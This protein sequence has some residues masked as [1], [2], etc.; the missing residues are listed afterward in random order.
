LIEG[1][2]KWTDEEIYAWLDWDQQREQ[3]IE[4]Q[5]EAE[6]VAA[7]GYGGDSRRGVSYIHAQIDTEDRAQTQQ[8]RFRY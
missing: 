4:Q 8:Y 7:G 1:Q 3:V 6:L 5:V 2:P